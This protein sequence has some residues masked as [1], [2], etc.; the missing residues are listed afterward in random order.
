MIVP[1]LRRRKHPINEKHAAILRER[2]ATDPRF[3][4]NQQPG[5]N[6]GNPTGINQYTVGAKTIT[7]S[8]TRYLRS[9][10]PKRL[11][12]MY[13]LPEGATYADVIF[14]AQADMACVGSLSHAQF[15]QG[16]VEGQFQG[17]GER[18]LEVEFI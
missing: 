5:V 1:K 17:P 3:T 4:V 9:A 11:R 10:A 8:G 7:E 2:C 16:V 13:D 15:V 14:A 6:N 18:K 12:E